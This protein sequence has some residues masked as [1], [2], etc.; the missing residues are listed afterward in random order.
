MLVTLFGVL[1]VGGFIFVMTYGESV[2]CSE[3]GQK[4]KVMTNDN[5]V[6]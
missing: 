5:K 1:T 2:L 6:G 3:N 4:D